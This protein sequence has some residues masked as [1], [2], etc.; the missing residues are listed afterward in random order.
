[1]KKS[2]VIMT[3]I[4]LLHMNMSTAATSVDTNFVTTD[5]KIPSGNSRTKDNSAAQVCEKKCSER[6]LGWG[7]RWYKTCDGKFICA[8]VAKERVN[9]IKQGW[10]QPMGYR[11]Q[12]NR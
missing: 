9:L 6:G 8:C 4:V 12:C 1:M 5:E 10:L 11:D 2:L 7:R 3:A